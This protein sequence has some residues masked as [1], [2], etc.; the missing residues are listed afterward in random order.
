MTAARASGVFSLGVANALALLAAVAAAA[1]YAGRMDAPAFA[2]WAL[3][4]AV[5]RAGLLLLDGGLKTA[6]VRRAL[7]PDAATQRRLGWL[8]AA[9]AVLLCAAVACAAGGL[10]LAGRLGMGEALLLFVYP[11]AYWLSYPPLFTALAR[12]ERAQRFGP[13]GRAEAASLALEFVL[14]ALLMAG[15]MAWWLAFAAAA[16][17]ARALRTVW[18]RQAASLEPAQTAGGGEGASQLLKEGSGVQAAAGLSMLRDQM[19]LWL[20]APW[21]G[22]HWAGVYTFALTACALASQVSV[23]TASRVALPALR[24]QSAAARWP[25]VLAQVRRLSIAT[26]PPLALLPA[27]LAQLDAAAW[28]G[29]WHEAVALVPWLALRMVPGVA[30]TALGAWLMVAQAPWRTARAHAAWTLCEITLALLALQLFGATGLAVAA[31]FGAWSGVLIFLGAAA[32]GLAP[33]P[34]LRALVSTLL[35]RPSLAAALTLGLW[36]QLQP[37]ALPLATLLLPLCWWAEASVRQW[38]YGLRAGWRMRPAR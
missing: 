18:V 30:T 5:S 32:P 21:F 10:A 13:V 6:L 36:A 19:H 22:A 4:L 20:L 8:S 35:V 26:L 14:P 28:D 31:A 25:L 33:G 38:A 16:V 11:A 9:L 24:A 15:G 29:R 2:H 7:M 3:A 34:R 23:Q 27:W 37:A 1:L 17:A 12:L